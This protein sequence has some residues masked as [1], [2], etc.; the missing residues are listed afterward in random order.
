MPY[1]EPD[2]NRL[3]ALRLAHEEAEYERRFD[4]EP[5]HCEMAGGKDDDDE[6]CEDHDVCPD[7]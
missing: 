4:Y 7:D 5:D 6:D 3:D 2:W 1:R